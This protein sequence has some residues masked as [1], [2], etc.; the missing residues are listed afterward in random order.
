MADVKKVIYSP[1]FKKSYKKLPKSVKFLAEKKEK[2][3]REN[4]F[5]K[6]LKT[7]KLHGRL[8]DYLS[9][10]INEEYRIIFEFIDEKT[11]YFHTTGK[12]DIYK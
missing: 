5:D 9:F 10:S 6:R 7:H 1:T 12:H 8:K 11:V 4:P 2:V 3:F